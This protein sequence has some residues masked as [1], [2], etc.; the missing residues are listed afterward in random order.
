MGLFKRVIPTGVRHGT[1]TVLFKGL[2]IETTTFRSESGYSDGRRPDRIEFASSIDEDLSRRDFTVNAMAFDLMDRS[3]VDPYDGRSDI[4]NKL[5][6]CV[7]DPFERFGEDGLRPLRALR[8]ASQLGFEVESVTLAA[9][10]ASLDRLGLVSAERVRDELGKIML[11]PRP[12]AGLRLME[13]TGILGAVIP[14]ALEGR[15]VWQK[16]SHR[17]DVLDHLFACADAAPGDLALRLAAFLHDIGK[18]RAI[19]IGSEGDPTFYGHEEISAAMSGEILRRLRFPNALVD[20]VTHLVRHHMFAYD[21]SW[22]DAAVRRFLARVGSSNLDRLLALR[23]SD[24]TGMTGL[25]VDPRSLE[26][27]RTRVELVLAKEHAF[28]LKDLAVGGEDLASIGVPK[29]PVMGRILAELLETVIDDPDLNKRERL[30]E[31][32]ARLKAKYGIP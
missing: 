24:G 5:L 7:G 29:G 17:F 15:G 27:L 8:L 23:L 3:L 22:T 25:P 19:G 26:P 21:D 10:P 13:R 31:I 4:A 28:G 18:P 2:S 1:V 12:S 30:L 16:G 20:E 14:E 9:I 32:G 11:S 6:R